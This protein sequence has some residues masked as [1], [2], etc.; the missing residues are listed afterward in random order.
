MQI[1]TIDFESYWDSECSLSKLSPL[2]YIRHREFEIISASIKIEAYPTDVFFGESDVRHALRNL[3]TK[4]RAALAH[5][6]TGFDAYVLHY[7]FGVN[8]KLW[9]DTLAMARPIHAKTTGLSLAKLVEHYAKQ[10]TAMGIKAKKDNTILLNT[11]GKHL[12]DFT[13]DERAHMATY[14]GDDSDQCYGIFQILKHHYTSAELWQIDALVRMRTEPGFVLD[15]ALL[16]AAASVERDR[17]FKSLLDLARMLGLSSVPAGVDDGEMAFQWD[18]EDSVVEAVKTELASAAKFSKLLISLGVEVPMKPSPSNPKN[19]VPALA[20]TD[21]AFIDLQEHD[22]PVVAAAARAR[23]DVKSTL[24]ETRIEKFQTAASLCGGLVPVPLRY[25]GADTTGR[26][27]G[28]EYN[29]Q[30]MTRINPDVP[31]PSDALRNSLLAPDDCLVIVADQSGIELRTNHFL[32]KVPSS[33]ALYQASP[34]K[35]D[36]YKAFA[37]TLYGKHVNDIIKSERHIGKLCLA[38]GT[39]VLTDVGEVPI[40]RVTAHHKVWDGVEWVTTLGA[41]FKGVQHV[42]THDGITATPDHEVWVSDGRKIPFRD[43]AAQSLRLARSGD[44]GAPL[45]FGGVGVH[46]ASSHQGVHT[47][48]GAVH[49]LQHNQADQL[50]QPAQGRHRG[51][52]ELLAE[53]RSASVAS[54][55]PGGSATAVHEPQRRGVQT[56]RG[57]GGGVSVSV[58]RRGSSVGGAEPGAGA[59]QGAGPSEQ[60][61]ALRAGEPAVGHTSAEHGQPDALEISGVPHVPAGAPGGPLCGQH[62]AQLAEQGPDTG[63]DHPSVGPAVV[64]TQGRVWDLLNCGP[65]S[66]FTAN[67]RLVSNCQLGLGFGAGAVTFQRIAKNMGG[68]DMPLRIDP[69]AEWLDDQGVLLASRSGEWQHMLNNTMT[70]QRVVQQW[71]AAYP[72]IAEGWR[73][74][75]GALFDIKRGVAREVDPWGLVSTCKEGLLLPSGRLIRYPDL[76]QIE[77]GEWPDGR[78]KTSWVYAHG[79]HMAHLTGPK[80]DENI[81]Q[82]LA[83]D[84]IFDCALEF[85]KRTGLR[86][87]LRVHDELVYIV[88]KG[89]A[90]QLLSEL[91]SILRTP[92]KWWPELITWSEGDAA[93]SYGAAK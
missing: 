69:P 31:R 45:G 56:V 43:A 60:R 79:R 58:R 5:N 17:K 71:R 27:S 54:P 28:E 2:Q 73:T 81:V 93:P 8:P 36:L 21:Q 67:G 38:E 42:I 83:R 65:R 29:M 30:N 50:C 55:A 14:N 88:P 70:A 12:S 77:D 78:P 62:A 68:I 22:N 10:L 3:D 32:W 41:I 92:P 87:K 25:C 23:L 39:L 89:E 16:E 80:V 11:K 66:R 74:C 37:S 82:A 76:R 4:K 40:E 84:S 57:A 18:D 51:V 61:W 19:T 86:P 47:R 1:M 9:L 91:Q 44:G 6:M 46:G 15:T 20:K 75:S 53:V 34:D 85:F 52:P 59:G 90:H 48:S 35:A 49:E 72:E 33:M 7:V 63:T 13:Q 64:Q 26:D 24:L